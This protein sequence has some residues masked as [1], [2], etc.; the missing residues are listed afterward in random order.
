MQAQWLNNCK[1]A[2][3][4]VLTE[5][6]SGKSA[7]TLV[8]ALEDSGYEVVM[9]S[10]APGEYRVVIASR[11][12][13]VGP[14]VLTAPMQNRFVSVRLTVRDAVLDLVGIYVPSRGPSGKRNVAKEP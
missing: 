12:G 10:D 14:G 11:I 9:P 2:D 7:H 8:E 3:L 1:D 6:S 4:V 13:V 5:V